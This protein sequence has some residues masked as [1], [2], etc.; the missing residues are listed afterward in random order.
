MG[1][2]GRTLFKTED[3]FL[4]YISGNNNKRLFQFLLFPAIY[5]WS[6]PLDNR[7]LH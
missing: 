1:R 2:E 3:Y 5:N 4:I 6:P 7:K